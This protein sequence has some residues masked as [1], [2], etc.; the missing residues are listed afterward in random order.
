MA[1]RAAIIQSCYVPWKGYFDIIH[2]V[3]CFI[4]LDNVQFTKHDWRNRN[5]IKLKQGLTWLSI[6]VGP[7]CNRL[8]QDVEFYDHHWQQ[9]HLKSL[10]HSCKSTPFFDKMKPLLYEIYQQHKW[11]NLSAFNQFVTKKIAQKYLNIQTKFYNANQY[12][13]S[14][15]KSNRIIKLL[16]AVEAT[17]YLSG[18]SAKNYLDE[19]LFKKAGIK[20]EYK[21]YSGYPEYK[22]LYPPFEHKVSILDLLFHVGP[23]APYYIWGWRNK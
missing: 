21:D 5:R 17:H 8:I 13:V 16:Q 15:Y 10:Q 2:D 11:T 9:L 14:G 4:F 22:Q 23:E 12:E 18:P 19:A 1:K 3:D 20:L 7:N 6:P